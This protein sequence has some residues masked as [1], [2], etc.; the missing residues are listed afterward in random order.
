MKKLLLITLVT[1][2]TVLNLN[3]KELNTDGGLKMPKAASTMP[4]QTPVE[5]IALEKAKIENADANTPSS[6]YI[7]KK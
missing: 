6:K 2:M 1:L 4:I 3:A 5:I 7:G